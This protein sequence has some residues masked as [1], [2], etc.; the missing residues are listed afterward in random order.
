MQSGHFGRNFTP[1]AIVARPDRTERETLRALTVSNVERW[2]G[3]LILFW[4]YE[5]EG[6]ISGNTA[7]EGRRKEVGCGSP[8]RNEQ[9]ADAP[10]EWV[11][12]RN[13]HQP[14]R[15]QLL[16]TPVPDSG[17][18]T[19]TSQRAEESK[20]GSRKRRT[21]VGIFA[22]RPQ[23][24]RADRRK[25]RVLRPPSTNTEGAAGGRRSAVASHGYGTR[26]VCAEAVSGEK[27]YAGS[28][29][30]R[31]RSL[32]RALRTPRARSPSPPKDA[33]LIHT[34][35]CGHEYGYARR[36]PQRERREH[37]LARHEHARPRLGKRGEIVRVVHAAV[38]ADGGIMSRPDWEEQRG[39]GAG[40][41]TRRQQGGRI[42]RRRTYDPSKQKQGRQAEHVHP[43]RGKRWPRRLTALERQKDVSGRVAWR[44]V[45]IHAADSVI[46]VVVW[47]W[48]QEV[49]ADITLQL[50]R[51]SQVLLIV[52]SAQCRDE[53]VVH[54]RAFCRA[55]RKQSRDEREMRIG[56]KLDEEAN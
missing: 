24:A 43:M 35:G 15:M 41:L 40:R 2:A 51:R 6:K 11:F 14:L 27:G 10:G 48:S 55:R 36:E 53:L 4:V 32:V 46:F 49:S 54:S 8:G 18:D 16:R 28:R 21:G 12:G 39:A 45:N 20:G 31:T 7:E 34:G 56:R 25:T 22:A 38:K 52:A 5:T 37:R 13:E 9:I 1:L 47:L 17:I 42:C 19:S 3:R 30:K 23:Q 44:R 29:K 26:G 33:P 50:A